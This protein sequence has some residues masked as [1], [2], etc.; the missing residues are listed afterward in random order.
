MA[1][2]IPYW[3]VSQNEKIMLRFS[4]REYIHNETVPFT[5]MSCFKQKHLSQPPKKK[6][7]FHRENDN[8]N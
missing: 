2:N 3:A 7:R 1:E 8:E 4:Q 5:K 6:Y